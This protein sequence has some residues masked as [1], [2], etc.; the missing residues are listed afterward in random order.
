MNGT[1][2]V[3]RGNLSLQISLPKDREVQVGMAKKILSL[4]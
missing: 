4:L 3:R 2:T 1:L